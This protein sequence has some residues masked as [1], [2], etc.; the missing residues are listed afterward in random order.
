MDF[1]I[2]RAHFWLQSSEALCLAFLSGIDL[3]LWR[4]RQ[5]IRASALSPCLPQMAFAKFTQTPFMCVLHLLSPHMVKIKGLFLQFF[6][7]SFFLYLLLWKETFFGD[8][9]GGWCGICLHRYRTVFKGKGPLCLSGD[10]ADPV[11]GGCRLSVLWVLFLTRGVG[12][13]TQKHEG[14]P[15]E[16]LWTTF[17]FVIFISHY[18]WHF[19]SWAF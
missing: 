2:P 17:S 8:R 11:T 19:W 7:R 12:V 14:T 10:H 3:S 15:G 5:F 6:Q 18:V 4:N 13:V 9:F 16:W 1:I